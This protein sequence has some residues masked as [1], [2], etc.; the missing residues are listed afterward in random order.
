MV[1]NKLIRF[2]YKIF[3]NSVLIKTAFNSLFYLGSLKK[4]LKSLTNVANI[5]DTLRF[6]LFLAIMNGVY[7]LLLCILRRILKDDRLAA[8]IAGFFAGLISSMEAKNRRQLLTVLLIGRMVDTT[9]NVSQDRGLYKRRVGLEGVAI[10]AISNVLMQYSMAY[11]SEVMNK[12]I[13]KKMQ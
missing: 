8:P 2:F 3:I 7:K 5:K 9:L 10:F 1:P 6:G 13:N 12:Q 4:L 11:E